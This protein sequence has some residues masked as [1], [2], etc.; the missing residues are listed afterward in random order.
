MASITIVGAIK[1]QVEKRADSFI[2]LGY[3]IEKPIELIEFKGPHFPFNISLE[4]LICE[5]K[6][7]YKIVLCKK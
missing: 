2:R 4:G 3:K 5:Q 7:E 1:A 6:K